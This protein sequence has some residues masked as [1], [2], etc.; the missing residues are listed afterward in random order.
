M[1]PLSMSA[2]FERFLAERRFLNNVTPSTIEW[3]QTA[4]KALQR[5]TETVRSVASARA[6]VPATGHRFADRRSVDAA[7]L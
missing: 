4:F 6:R 1:D 5:E 2:L 7:V 3:Y